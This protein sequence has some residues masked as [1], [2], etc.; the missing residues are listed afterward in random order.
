M[1]FETSDQTPLKCASNFIWAKK[2]GT[3]DAS[4]FIDGRLSSSDGLFGL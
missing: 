2:K 1:E 3:P 4:L